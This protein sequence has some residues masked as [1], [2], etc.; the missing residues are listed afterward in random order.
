[1]NPADK[2][3]RRTREFEVASAAPDRGR[4]PGA[5]YKIPKTIAAVNSSAS[6]LHRIT[7][8]VWH[9]KGHGFPQLRDS[10]IETGDAGK[11]NQQRASFGP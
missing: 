11:Q 9:T 8:P 4:N 10:N 1:M 2:C 5:T 7:A 3:T 6:T